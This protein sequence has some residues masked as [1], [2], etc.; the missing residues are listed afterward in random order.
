MVQVNVQA[1]EDKNSL[2]SLYKNITIILKINMEFLFY[3]V[4]KCI[5]KLQKFKIHKIYNF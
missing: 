1:N 2:S 4:K 5:M 3:N